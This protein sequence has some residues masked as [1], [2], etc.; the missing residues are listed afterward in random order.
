LRPRPRRDARR[1][2]DDAGNKLKQGET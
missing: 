1:A 2:A